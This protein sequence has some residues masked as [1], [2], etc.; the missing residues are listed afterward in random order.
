LNDI[1]RNLGLNSKSISDGRKLQRQDQFIDDNGEYKEDYEEGD[2]T[3][4][5]AGMVQKP[6][7][8]GGTNSFNVSSN[9]ISSFH[10]R[11]FIRMETQS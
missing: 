6:L 2:V 8:G 9:L 1:Y 4:F 3:G 5:M 7:A 11:R 10:S